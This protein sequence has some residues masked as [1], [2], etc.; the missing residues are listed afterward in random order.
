MALFLQI[1][2][3]RD[4]IAITTVYGLAVLVVCLMVQEPLPTAMAVVAFLVLGATL[5]Y[6]VFHQKHIFLLPY[7][8]GQV[9]SMHRTAALFLNNIYRKRHKNIAHV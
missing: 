2:A 9:R 6:G 1:M 7:L 3:R 5:L 4:A 8:F